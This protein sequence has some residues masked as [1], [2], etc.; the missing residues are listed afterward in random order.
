MDLKQKAI[1]EIN[2][3]IMYLVSIKEDLNFFYYTK[4]RISGM[5]DIAHSLNLI[6]DDQAINYYTQLSLI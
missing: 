6:T 5:I 4:N 1:N 2:L 3:N